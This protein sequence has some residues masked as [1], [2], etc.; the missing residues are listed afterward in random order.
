ME[1]EPRETAVPGDEPEPR[2][3]PKR[4]A[5]PQDI[6]KTLRALASLGE[7]VY[8][9]EVGANVSFR[10]LILSLEEEDGT[11]R[12]QI[13]DDDGDAPQGPGAL[14]DVAYDV[15]APLASADLVFETRVVGPGPSPE[16]WD[17]KTPA[18][19]RRWRRRTHRRE[20]CFGLIDVLLR[21][22]DKGEGDGL[23][24]TL[25]DLSLVGIG[26]SLPAA[27]RERV[28][29]GSVFEECYLVLNGKPIAACRVEILHLKEEPKT[30]SVLAGARLV[31]NDPVAKARVVKL[32]AAMHPQDDEEVV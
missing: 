26:V 19:I 14:G 5:T 9:T 32:V 27:A 15:F 7:P 18:G 23:L 6:A 4:I 3:S 13:L 24:G 29:V 17:L 2:Y 30:D 22:R 31:A 11:F 20:H 16:Q 8:L 25:R 28:A 12:I 21:Q 10:A 1:A